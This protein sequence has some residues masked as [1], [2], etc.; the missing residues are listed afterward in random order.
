MADHASLFAADAISSAPTTPP[1]AS[2]FAGELLGLAHASAHPS[3]PWSRGG[4]IFL[5]GARY[6]IATVSCCS[7]ERMLRA[8]GIASRWSVSVTVRVAVIPHER[9]ETVSSSPSRRAAQQI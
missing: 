2:P 7:Q 1:S 9:E 6:V 5:G 8:Q 4:T 3:L